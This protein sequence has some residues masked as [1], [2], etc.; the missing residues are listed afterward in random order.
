MR[1]RNKTASAGGAP[2]G[3][4]EE[5][6]S[7]EGDILAGPRGGQRSAGAEAPRGEPAPLD[8]AGGAGITRDE[9]QVRQ[10]QTIQGLL[11]CRTVSQRA[12]RGE[13][14]QVLV[15]FQ[16]RGARRTRSWAAR[17]WRSGDWSPERV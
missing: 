4:S 2:A 12:V 13:D 15:E 9:V 1:K 11:G 16:S 10:Q 3:R 6:G 14:P 5:E 8:A 17:S 7:R